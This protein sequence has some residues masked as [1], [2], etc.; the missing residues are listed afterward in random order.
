MTAPIHPVTNR[1]VRRQRPVAAPAAAIV[2]PALPAAPLQAR[3]LPLSAGVGVRVSA[4]NWMWI[5]GGGVVGMLLLGP[6]G[7]IGGAIAGAMLTR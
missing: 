5:V 4:P 2:A 1:R 6:L 7:A 3:T